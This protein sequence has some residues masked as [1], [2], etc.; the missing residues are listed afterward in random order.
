MKKLIMLLIALVGMSSAMA[1]WV[2]QNSGTTNNLN[3]IYFTNGN[4]GYAVGDFG[5]I[6][7]TTNG[8]GSPG[9]LPEG[10]TFTTQE[11]I[12]NFQTN[13]PG[14]TEIEGDIFIVGAWPYGN[15]INNLNGLN[16]ITSIGGN[17]TVDGCSN[18]I[19][20]TG[21][22]N[23]ISV[24]GDLILNG[25]YAMTSFTGLESLSSIGGKFWIGM[26]H[27][28]G[29]SP[30]G[31]YGNPSLTSV[32][33]LENLASIGGELQIGDNS[34]LTSLEGLENLHSIAGSLYIFSND[35]L[36][37]LSG[38]ENLNSIPGD[39]VI[40]N[41]SLDSLSGLEN[42]TSIEGDLIINWNHSLTS[43]S[44][45]E[46]IN[47]ASIQNLE[48]TNNISLSTC[49]AQSIC[50]YLA[51][52][53]GTVGI[54]NNATGCNN[55]PEVASGCGITL[56][57][58]PYGNYYFFSQSDIDSYQSGY[59]GCVDLAGNVEINGSGINDLSGLIGL[60][61]VEGN[62]DIGNYNNGTSL[63]NLSGLD[64]LNFLGGS[65][66]IRKNNYL[67]NLTGLEN[68]NFIAGDLA[69]QSNSS[70]A[71]L[72]GLDHLDS[73]GGGLT[74]N[75]NHLENM[76]G[77]GSLIN[78]GGGFSIGGGYDNDYHLISL[79]GLDYLTSVG[80]LSIAYT[81]VLND[82][83]GLAS[84]SSIG[85]WLNLF[86]NHSL[87][88]LSGLDN[89]EPASV[90]NLSITYNNKLSTCEVKSICD[91]LAAPN[92][93]IYIHNNAPGCNSPEEVEA[94]CTVGAGESAVGGQQSAVSVYPNPTFSRS[95][96]KYQISK[97][98][99]VML[100]IVD[101]C[102]SEVCTLVNEEQAPGEY[103]VAFNASRLPAGIYLVRL[104]AG[105]DISI[106]KVVV[107]K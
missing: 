9:C 56:N 10:I 29:G 32:S 30:E 55:P 44:G 67:S 64:S 102:G 26:C 68:L 82:I 98:K 100:K 2:P 97:S 48:I 74:I 107:M 35:S 6:L 94:A 28:C 15:D 57:C 65:L 73:I 52:P 53:N 42:L 13:Y 104:Q 61:S 31:F 34:T 103:N 78:I 36:T 72:T 87:T 3:S 14:C 5:T 89:I 37:S 8:G 18:L 101:V 99:S 60:S 59:S 1:Q 41:F 16:T 33:G 19:N 69:I 93:E 85:G 40:S 77:L 46:N 50:D 4:T 96:I 23:L 106:V 70:L 12:D 38:L 91:Y 81:I 43:L 88:N 92:G 54:Y 20:L 25:N 62:I 83:S 71:E 66:T 21:L 105:E 51:S 84:V 27:G 76:E 7:K 47:A 17:L 49:E 90:S 63:T 75:E 80:A 79:S 58:L 86:A 39:F 22:E 11:Q 24:A 95:E 45:I